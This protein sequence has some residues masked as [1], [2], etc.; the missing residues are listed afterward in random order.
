MAGPPLHWGNSHVSCDG[1]SGRSPQQ[2]LSL[3]WRFH[4]SFWESIPQALAPIRITASNREDVSYRL[5]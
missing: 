2:M 4:W 3:T 1:Y 5:E